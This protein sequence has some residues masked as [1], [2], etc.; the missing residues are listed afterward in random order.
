MGLLYHCIVQLYQLHGQCAA[1][2]VY[3]LISQ[4]D[5]GI[6]MT[7]DDLVANI[8]TIARSGSKVSAK[9]VSCVMFRRKCGSVA[10]VQEMELFS[11]LTRLCN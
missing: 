8:G 10:A 4:Q 7:R 2:N 6:G 9:C 1:L 11:L 5:T 3:F